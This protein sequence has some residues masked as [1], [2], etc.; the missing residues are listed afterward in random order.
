MLKS[1]STTLSKQLLI[2]T[3]GGGAAFW[4]ANFAISRTPIAAEYRAAL[5]ISYIPMLLES[6]L[7]GAMIG[8]CV[9][10]FLLRFFDKIPTQ[11]PI[12]KSVIFTI[13]VLIVVTI[14]IAGPSSYLAT[15]NVLHYFLVGTAFNT[16]RFLA[17]GVVIGYLYDKLNGGRVVMKAIVCPKYGSADVLQLEEVVKP[18]P[19]DDEV[20]IKIHAASI[21]ARD[22]RFM[23]AKPFFIRLTSGGFLHPKNK[24]LGADAAG[25]IE[26]VGS[27]VRQFKPGDDVFGYMPSATGRGTFGEYVCA[28]ENLFTLKPVNLI[29]RAG[30]GGALGGDDCLAGIM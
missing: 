1:V 7:G 12:S 22:W 24:I 17:L 28:R 11:D 18:A 14:L 6:L 13:I 30:C 23:R 26:V 2:L 10:Y 15:S 5:S 27:R 19:Q 4:L 9:G 3:I 8:L 20:L 16:I 29:F 21:N 25:R